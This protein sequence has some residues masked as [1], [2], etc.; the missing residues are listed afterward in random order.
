MEQQKLTPKRHGD[1][2][3]HLWEPSLL[4]SLSFLF[5]NQRLQEIL[6]F[7]EHPRKVYHHPSAL[8][9]MEPG[10][11][12]APKPRDKARRAEA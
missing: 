8:W 9:E 12:F 4:D 5:G 2:I 1:F 3:M 6:F 10:R 7:N 11:M